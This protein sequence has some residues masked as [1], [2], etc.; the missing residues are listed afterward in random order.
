MNVEGSY[1]EAVEGCV[2]VFH[3]A[4]PMD[5]ESDDPEVCI[6][7]PTRQYYEVENNVSLHTEHPS[8]ARHDD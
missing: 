1:D 4:T 6:V 3:M 7:I 5:F 2:G 8:Y